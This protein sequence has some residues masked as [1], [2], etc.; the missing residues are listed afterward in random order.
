MSKKIIDNGSL[1][2]LIDIDERNFVDHV[3]AAVYTPMVDIKGNKFLVRNRDN[4][5]VQKHKFGN[6]SRYFQAITSRYDRTAQPSNAVLL[7]DKGSGKTMLSEDFGNWMLK[8]DIPVLM[9]NEP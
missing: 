9:I 8:Q 2:S 5:S 4:F 6:H 1:L 3:P 7:G